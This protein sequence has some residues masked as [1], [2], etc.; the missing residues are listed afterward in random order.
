MKL[1]DLL[2]LLPSV[3]DGWGLAA[4]VAVLL[5]AYFAGLLRPPRYPRLNRVGHNVAP[6][7]TTATMGVLFAG[8]A[9]PAARCRTAPLDMLMY[10]KGHGVPQDYAAAVSWWRKAAE[11]GDAVAQNKLGTMKDGA[12]RRI[13]STATCGSTWRRPAG[14][15]TR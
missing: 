6:T 2:L 13:M 1:P 10:L 8:G 11:Q 5:Y 12:S 4:L 9:G 15:K 7:T 3:H 14:T